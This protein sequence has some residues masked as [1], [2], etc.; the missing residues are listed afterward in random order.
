M[1]DIT[2]PNSLFYFFIFVIIMII[3][4][5]IVIIFKLTEH[6]K[7]ELHTKCTRCGYDIYISSMNE[8]LKVCEKKN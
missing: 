3:I 1:I 5:I 7:D 4:T 2:I 8:H 6:K